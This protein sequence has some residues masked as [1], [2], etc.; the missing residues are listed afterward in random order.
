MSNA[1]ERATSEAKAAATSA[2]ASA[3]VLA[4]DAQRTFRD[5]AHHFERAVQEGVEQIRAQSRAYAD[6][7]GEQIE[8]AQRYVVEH[9]RERPL[10][11]TGVAVGLG[12]V[13]GMLLAGGRR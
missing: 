12:V 7:A 13:I 9:V 3:Q 8:E 10:A 5:A 6:T 4:E 1:A 2:A 11:A